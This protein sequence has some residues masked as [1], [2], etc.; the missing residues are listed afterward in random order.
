LA[1]RANSLEDYGQGSAGWLAIHTR[2]QHEKMVARSLA[3]KGF[4][5][6]LP[7]YTRI[8][9]WSDR[10]KELSAPLFPGYVFL[11]GHLEQEIRILTT[12]GVLGL[13]GF[14]GVPAIIPEVEIE[15]VRQAIARRVQVEPYPFLKCGDWVRVKSGPLEGLEGILVRYKRQFRLV[16]SVQ[17]IQKSVAVEVDVWMVERVPKPEGRGTGH[18]FTFESRPSA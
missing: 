16:L 13:V 3:F 1:D 6:F 5:V 17:L 14:G 11:R 7:L 12:P 4:E 10:T 9:Q 18:A 15:A 2:H 8:R